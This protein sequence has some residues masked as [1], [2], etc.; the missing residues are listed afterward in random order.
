VSSRQERVP[1]PAGSPAD[2][3]ASDRRLALAEAAFTLKD[4][5]RGG[6]V[7]R[8]V[9]DPESVADHSWGTALLCLLYAAEAGVDRDKAVTMALVHDLAE[10]ETGDV[11]ARAHASD[12]E[13]SEAVK[14]S[15][16]ADAMNRLVPGDLAGLRS[17]WQ[18][19]EDRSD[20]TALFV[21]DMNLID[22]CLQAVIYHDER[23]YDEDVVIPSQGG[24]THLDE[25]FASASGRLS[26]ALG[27]RLFGALE[28][29][30]LASR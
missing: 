26:T 29:R 16:E 8:G 21:R 24:F 9:R 18:S 15:L 11:V 1:S 4:E 17:A 10:A 28:A 22:M 27:R 13:V 3:W 19:Y 25:F 12:R 20:A 7:L 14:A 30:Y 2:T 5:P 23:R 6:W